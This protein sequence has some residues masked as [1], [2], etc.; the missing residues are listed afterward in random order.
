MEWVRYGWDTFRAIDT[1][2][3]IC[4]EMGTSVCVG[5]G[6]LFVCVEGEK[7]SLWCKKLG[8]EHGE[9]NCNYSETKE[10]R[11]EALPE[12]DAE[13]VAQSKLTGGGCDG[14]RTQMGGA[15]VQDDEGDGVR[16]G[17]RVWNGFWVSSNVTWREI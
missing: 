2:G 13:M 1:R 11:S 14:V 7:P 17:E 4:V 12:G 6:E 10:G 16:T 5:G 9:F 3:E 15:A 8:L